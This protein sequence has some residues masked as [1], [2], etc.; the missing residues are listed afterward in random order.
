MVNRTTDLELLETFHPP[1]TG[2]ES[3]AHKYGAAQR[4]GIDHVV[5]EV[6]GPGEESAIVTLIQRNL[7]GFEEAGT[8]LAST[9]RRLEGIPGSISGPGKC[10]VVARDRSTGA[11]IGGVGI[12]PL[13]GLSPEEG[14]G[15]LR[16]LV[17]DAHW[18]G[19]GIGARILHRS[20]DEARSLGYRSLYLETTPAMDLAQKLFLRFGFRAVT[21]GSKLI[22][23]DDPLP[24]YFILENLNGT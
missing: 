9:F 15:E 10:F 19:L 11:I 6:L 5:M 14:I 8:V 7:A 12:G 20:I 16:D 13:H 18:R 1:G 22:R 2:G 17:L 3:N 21:H 23:K 24:C 4:P